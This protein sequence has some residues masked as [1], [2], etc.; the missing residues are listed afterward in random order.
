MSYLVAFALIAGLITWLERARTNCEI[1][2]RARLRAA[3]KVLAKELVALCPDVP[4]TPCSGKDCSKCWED[5]ILDIF[6]K[7]LY[8]R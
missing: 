5:Y 8:T 6:K 4:K 7:E 2:T 3:A 1:V